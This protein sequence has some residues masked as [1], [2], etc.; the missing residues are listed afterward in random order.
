MPEKA[1]YIFRDYVSGDEKSIVE[2]F[3]EVF[4]PVI[5]LA[6][7]QWKFQGNDPRENVHAK[8]CFAADG[9][10]LGHA[11]AIPLRGYYHGHPIPIFQICDVMVHPQARGHWGARN[12]FTVLL[13]QLLDDIAQH[14]PQAFCYGFPGRRPFLLGQRVGVYEQVE[15]AVET[16]RPARRFKQPFYSVRAMDWR[17]KRLD[18]FWK[19][20]RATL[21]LTLVR[22][23][24]FLSWR[25][26]ANPFHAYRLLGVFVLG[27][28]LGWA[29][30]REEAHQWLIV[31][32]LCRRRWLNG[33][34]RALDHAARR[35]GADSSK[36]WLPEPWRSAA[37]GPSTATE[38]VTTHMI[39]KPRLAT[40]QVRESLYYT[41]GDLDIF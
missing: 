32:M 6:Q 17:D 22:D 12:V 38:V 5:T 18:T 19:T 34:L 2:L 16:T 11:G 10:L 35:A 20:M 13:R 39:R 24:D 4:G 28:L 8:L 21:P 25:Y 1:E 14:Y 37:G 26:A 15:I 41:M 29:V 33:V 31:D 3:A 36:I 30:V 7:W 40:A 23:S 27:A 9:K